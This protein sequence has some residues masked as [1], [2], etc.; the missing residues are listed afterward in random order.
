MNISF[1]RIIAKVTLIAQGDV[2]LSVVMTLCTTLGAVVL[3]PLL[4]MI[5]AGTYVPVHA[6]KLSISTLQGKNITLFVT[7]SFSIHRNCFVI[8]TSGRYLSAALSYLGKP[9]RRAISIEVGMQNSSLGVVLATAHF[10]SPLV[11]L[12]P[13]VSV[14][15]MNIM[16]STLESVKALQESVKEMQANN[17]RMLSSI[18]H[19]WSLLQEEMQEDSTASDASQT[20]EAIVDDVM[21]VQRRS[22]AERLIPRHSMLFQI[23]QMLQPF[24]SAS[25]SNLADGISDEDEVFNECPQLVD[26]DEL[27][28]IKYTEQ[29]RHMNIGSIG[30]TIAFQVGFQKKLVVMVMWK[31][32]VLPELIS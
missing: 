22:L 31:A 21:A 10:A 25:V 28:S 14:V 2:P 18:R 27:H 23:F 16:G 1:L 32:K 20:E 24:I 17:S 9:Q 26:S 29:D 5:L 15:I 3:T 12:P 7:L 4:T 6:I 13:A 8:R 11:A 19:I 30:S